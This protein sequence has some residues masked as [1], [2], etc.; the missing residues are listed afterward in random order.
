MKKMVKGLLLASTVLLFLP[1]FNTVLALSIPQIIVNGIPIETD[2]AP[3]IISGRTMVPVRA[4]AEA[5]GAL[6]TWDEKEQ[7]VYIESQDDSFKQQLT[8]LQQ[9]VLSTDPAETIKEWVKAC[10]SRNGA[11]QYA[12]YSPELKEKTLTQFKELGWVTG[13]SSP[14]IEDFKISEPQPEG[15]S[16]VYQVDFLMKTSSDNGLWS[17]YT[18]ILSQIEE[19]W[20]ITK[21]SGDD[22]GIVY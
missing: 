6:V 3:E 11:L 1:L 16:L 7:K 14:W 20:F 18:V 4:V 12:L 2:V 17:S 22:T 9:A 13:V 19:K 10:Q 21:I 8:L 5:L 15:E